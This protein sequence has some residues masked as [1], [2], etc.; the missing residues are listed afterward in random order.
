[1][2][3]TSIIANTGDLQIDG[4][5][6]PVVEIVNDVTG[7]ILAADEV[8][9]TTT[10]S[11]RIFVFDPDPIPTGLL[12]SPNES[13]RYTVRLSDNILK[14]N[15]KPAFPN[16]VAGIGFQWSFTVSNV[17]D[18]LPPYI[19]NWRPIAN[20]IQPRNIIINVTFNEAINP[21]SVDIGAVKVFADGLPVS[22]ELFLSGDY[23]KVEFF[24]ESICENQP[25]NTCGEPIFCLPKDKTIK[26]LVLANSIGGAIDG[27]QDASSNSLDANRNGHECGPNGE[28][29]DNALG[30][31]VSGGGDYDLG[32]QVSGAGDNAFWEFNTNV[33][34]AV[35]I[36]TTSI[37]T[38][39]TKARLIFSVS[40]SK[41]IQV[42]RS[43]TR[44]TA[45]RIIDFITGFSI[46]NYSVIA[47]IGVNER[48]TSG[49]SFKNTLVT[50][51]IIA[52]GQTQ[53]IANSNTICI[54]SARCTVTTMQLIITLFTVSNQTITAP[55]RPFI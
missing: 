35:T 15:G 17:I 46:L 32:N 11:N 19:I 38:C 31:C 36:N 24:P 55:A 27:I 37:I 10:R 41:W 53:R 16:A 40:T 49:S 7:I 52:S 8:N 54:R 3:V 6:N 29:Y 13:Q 45:P 22:G 21:I 1:M 12:G 47:A 25:L 5:G 28:P 30:Q 18:I 39:F 33:T 51:P 20:S 26:T 42:A 43:G 4:Q 14:T 44:S 48:Y 23:R 50:A 34:A 2:D 9:A